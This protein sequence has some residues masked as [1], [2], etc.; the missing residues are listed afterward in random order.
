VIFRDADGRHHLADG[1]HRF[2]AHA[3][4]GHQTLLADVREGTQTDAL[5]FALGA[6]RA[7]GQRLSQR[8]VR[9]AIEL[10][11]GAWPDQSTKIIA[12]QIGCSQPYVASIK[13][14]LL[15][16]SADFAS[17]VTGKDGRTYKPNRP[18]TYKA[19][20]RTEIA[21]LV[22]AGEPSMVICNKLGVRAA[23]VA[24]V[25]R[26]LGVRQA[27]MTRGAIEGRREEMRRLA[28]EGHSSRQ[29]AATVGIRE[30]TVR[31][32]LGRMG[33]QVIADTVTRGLHK[34]DPR[35]IVT[36]IVMDAEN[37]TE[38]VDLIDFTALDH[39]DIT[40]ALASLKK[41]R[42]RLSAFIRRL[43][44]EQQHGQAAANGGAASVE[45]P[46]GPVRADRDPA[47]PRHAA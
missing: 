34:H 30:E 4:L 29:I 41:S 11:L 40:D 8:D 23:L 17:R 45:D 42:D 6:N 13:G 21:A 25:R 15:Q 5:W 39:A 16:L 46:A 35:R 19:E 33:V 43:M 1:W 7:H 20:T 47:G 36:R 37:L 22:K 14:A 10:A 24:D 26:E 28:T 31:R 3:Q 27:D 12:E 2:K 32:T 18:T 9:H 38:G 44:Q